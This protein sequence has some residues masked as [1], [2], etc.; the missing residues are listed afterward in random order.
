MYRTD[1]NVGFVQ[2]DQMAYYVSKDSTKP[3]KIWDLKTLLKVEECSCENKK[4]SFCLM[5]V[6][7]TMFCVAE[8]PIQV[9]EW[10]SFFR[11]KINDFNKQKMLDMY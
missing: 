5:F 7:R 3:Q 6:D 2:S 10:I 9:E 4:N 1:R 11:G 8:T